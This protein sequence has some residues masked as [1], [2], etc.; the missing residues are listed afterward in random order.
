MRPQSRRMLFYIH[1]ALI[2]GM[3]MPSCA[4]AQQVSQKTKESVIAFEK[5]NDAMRKLA[6]ESRVVI[7]ELQKLSE[8]EKS[9][10]VALVTLSKA[11]SAYEAVRVRANEEP[12]RIYYKTLGQ[13]SPAYKAPGKFQSILGACFDQSVGCLSALQSCEAEGRSHDDCEAD[14]GVIQACGAEAT[15]FFSAF[16]KLEKVI[17]D[18]LGGRDPWPPQPFPY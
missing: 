15:C 7:D 17:P 4:Q 12:L 14:P 16:L 10:V 8:K 13:L 3:F 18:I 11:V 9:A 5:R 6:Q 1:A 2:L